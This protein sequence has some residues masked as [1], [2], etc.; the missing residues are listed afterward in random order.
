MH[1]A[2]HLS[3]CR[4]ASWRSGPGQEPAG[5]P[6]AYGGCERCERLSKSC[7]AASQAPPA[8]L[9]S[10]NSLQ[11]RL[12]TSSSPKKFCGWDSMGPKDIQ[13]P[14]IPCAT[15]AAAGATAAG[16]DCL[17]LGP[18]GSD[19][20]VGYRR[21]EVLG[22][23]ALPKIRGACPPWRGMGASRTDG[24][25]P[26]EAGGVRPPRAA[27]RAWNAS[28]SVAEQSPVMFCWSCTCAFFMQV[29]HDALG[30]CSWPWE[31]LGRASPP[32]RRRTPS[33]VC[34][35]FPECKRL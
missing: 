9:A 34:P 30:L 6:V 28:S 19:G 35:G 2:R 29:V 8:R 16:F 10:R 26:A 4:Q 5:R 25:P 7:L 18:A 1:V 17:V 22:S 11:S 27:R 24:V 13:R 15:K 32:S 31:G 21:G 14:T 12:Q 3:C 20:G 33:Y 23:S